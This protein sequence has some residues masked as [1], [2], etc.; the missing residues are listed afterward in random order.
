[1]RRIFS[2]LNLNGDTPVRVQ[3]LLGEWEPQRVPRTSEKKKARISVSVAFA[4]I[5]VALFFLGNFFYKTLM[6]IA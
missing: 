4:A 6:G 3:P 2:D 1:M 5:V